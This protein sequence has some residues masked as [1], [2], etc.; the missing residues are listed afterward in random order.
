MEPDAFQD[1][2]R[3]VVGG[4]DYITWLKVKVTHLLILAESGRNVPEE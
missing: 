4:Q 2:H 3:A 1:Q